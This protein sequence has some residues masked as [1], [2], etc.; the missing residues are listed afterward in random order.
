MPV[1]KYGYGIYTHDGEQ[2]Y[3]SGKTDKWHEM[4]DNS[5]SKT[6]QIRIAYVDKYTKEASAYT[7]YVNFQNN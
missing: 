6:V 3:E 4:R 7:Y 2:V 5:S 1:S